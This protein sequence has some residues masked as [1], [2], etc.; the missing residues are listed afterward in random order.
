MPLWADYYQGDEP[1]NNNFTILN[2][3]RFKL[4]SSFKILIHINDKKE[5]HEDR[6]IYFSINT[7]CINW[8]VPA[9]C[10]FVQQQPL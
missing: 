5:N 8:L 7:M 2:T 3:I 9:D 1:Q 10:S 4:A 6:D